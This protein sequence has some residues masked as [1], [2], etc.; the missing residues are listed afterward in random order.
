M[1]GGRRCEGPATHARW[2]PWRR[3]NANEPSGCVLVKRR[4][5]TTSFA[6]KRQR[7]TANLR[8]PSCHAAPRRSRR[9]PSDRRCG[10]AVSR[11]HG[12]S[13]AAAV[14]R[15]T[16]RIDDR[17]AARPVAFPVSP[18][19]STV[20][21]GQILTGSHP[22]IACEEDAPK[23]SRRFGSENRGLLESSGHMASPVFAVRD[24]NT[25]AKLRRKP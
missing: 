24:P 1:A 18:L 13:T 5:G 16:P 2:Q 9:T 19:F 6:V 23:S 7:R 17:P 25:R 3:F 21:Q 12:R 10:R 15:P 11:S 4:W 22:V 14:A 8:R 20:W